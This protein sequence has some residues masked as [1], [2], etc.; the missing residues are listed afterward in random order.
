M[1][2]TD[3]ELKAFCKGCEHESKRFNTSFYK[4]DPLLTSIEQWGKGKWLQ[5]R[6]YQL[7]ADS[8]INC[9]PDSFIFH[10]K[11]NP[12]TVI[13]LYHTA[14]KERIEGYQ[15]L[16]L[17]MGRILSKGRLEIGG[18]E[19]T[20]R[21]NPI[22]EVVSLSNGCVCAVSRYIPFQNEKDRVDSTYY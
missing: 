15:R 16:T 8:D 11:E 9:G 14:T 22:D 6:F 3:S 12:D 2:E 7:L 21:V 5:C 20:I 10:P 19:F 1:G 17:D 13:K 18:N 4:D